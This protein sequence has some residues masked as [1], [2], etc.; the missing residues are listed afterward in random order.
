L[1]LAWRLGA[2][3]AWFAV[4]CRCLLVVVVAVMPVCLD[5]RLG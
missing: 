3:P 5:L 4:L 2:C 1:V